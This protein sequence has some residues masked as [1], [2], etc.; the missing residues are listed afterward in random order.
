MIRSSFLSSYCCNITKLP[1]G[2]SSEVLTCCFL[3]QLFFIIIPAG[4]PELWHM[5]VQSDT[6]FLST[7][8]QFFSLF[9]F[10]DD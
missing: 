7:Q 10:F 1:S 3:S 2:G 6:G 4:R 9:F 5:I 8:V